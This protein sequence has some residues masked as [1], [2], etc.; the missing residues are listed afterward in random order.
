MILVQGVEVSNII[1]LIGQ[2][3]SSATG[4]Y[5]SSKMLDSLYHYCCY[6]ITSV[7]HILWLLLPPFNSLSSFSL[8]ASFYHSILCYLYTHTCINTHIY[9]CVCVYTYNTHIRVCVCIH[10]FLF[11]FPPHSACTPKIA[12]PFPAPAW[13]WSHC[14][15]GPEPERPLGFLQGE[16]RKAPGQDV[17]YCLEMTG[18]GWKLARALKTGTCPNPWI[19]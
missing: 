10:V 9:I 15:L 3:V 12:W 5:C 7:P 8:M 4:A 2:V 18:D 16:S 1:T 11:F 17:V 6:Y 13:R 19:Q 14:R